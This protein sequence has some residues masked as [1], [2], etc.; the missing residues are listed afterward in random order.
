MPATEM[1]KIAYWA[2]HAGAVGFVKELAFRPN[3]PSG[4]FKRHL[5]AVLGFK[6]HQAGLMNLSV[7]GNSK[8]SMSRV[9]HEIPMMP[10][11]DAL[12]Q[13]LVEAPEMLEE[14]ARR[15]GCGEMPEA[16]M[17]HAVAVASGHKALPISI[18]IDGVQER[19]LAAFLVHERHHGMPTFAWCLAQGEN[20]PLR[21]QRVVLIVDCI[22]LAPLELRDS[23]SGSVA[24][25]AARRA[26]AR[27]RRAF[28][29]ARWHAFGVH[30]CVH[31]VEG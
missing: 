12:L 23:G 22:P 17:Q 18:Y 15:V 3:A 16:Y 5:D 25:E 2:S 30:S 4:H 27:G 24:C 21:L 28:G 7:P 8:S 10:V 1:C 31:D 6:T 20:L 9:V 13:E 11:Y 26:V 14:L 19:Y 29:S